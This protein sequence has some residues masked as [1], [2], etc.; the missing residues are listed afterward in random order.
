MALCLALVV[1]LRQQNN[2]KENT[3]LQ[4]IIGK[5]QIVP[6]DAFGALGHGKVQSLPFASV[7]SCEKNQ[8]LGQSKP[9]HKSKQY[10]NARVCS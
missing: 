10:L 4:S 9:R 8:F 3:S 5:T 2:Y 1:F 6:P 7:V